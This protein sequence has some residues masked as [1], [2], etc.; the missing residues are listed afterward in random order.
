[1]KRYS[2]TGWWSQPDFP[3]LAIVKDRA[4]IVGIENTHAF[5][6]I[7]IVHN[8]GRINDGNSVL[9]DKNGLA[10]V[11][12]ATLDLKKG[13]VAFDKIYARRNDIISYKATY[14]KEERCWRGTFDGNATGQGTTAFVIQE[15][16]DSLFVENQE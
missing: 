7:L 2:I 14:R 15:L 1:M 3:E 12:N 5:S 10:E 9:F 8:D 4:G 11:L 6:G 13:S 16:P